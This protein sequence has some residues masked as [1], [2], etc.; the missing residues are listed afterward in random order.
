M[1]I[2]DKN[3]TLHPYSINTIEN[4]NNIVKILNFFKDPKKHTIDYSNELPNLTGI[5]YPDN[6]CF[7]ISFD[8]NNIIVNDGR[9]F[10][11]NNFV[12]SKEETLLNLNRKKDYLV[13]PSTWS[14][15]TIPISDSFITYIIIKNY[16]VDKEHFIGYYIQDYEN[17]KMGLI[18]R[19]DYVNNIDDI[20]NDSVLIGILQYDRDNK[21]RV[22]N[23]ELKFEDSIDDTIFVTFLEPEI[24]V[25]EV[26]GG[27]LKR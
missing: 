9:C 23:V 14:N 16:G 24:Y 15:S 10:I 8:K 11:N 5:P 21:G 17:I 25:D 27:I 4:I 3:F 2:E 18:E 22:D 19:I 13:D 6:C 12:L 26:D 7:G 20:Q 1:E